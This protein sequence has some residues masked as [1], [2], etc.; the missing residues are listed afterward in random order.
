MPGM[1]VAVAMSGG[2][3]SAVAAYL[4]KREGHEVVGFFLHLNAPSEDAA[5]SERRCCSADDARDAQRCAE[6]LGIDFYALPYRDRFAAIVEDFVSEYRAGRTPYPCVHCNQDLKFGSLMTLAEGIGA[7]AVATGHYA[8]RQEASGRVRLLRGLDPDKDQSFVLFGLG[9]AQLARARFPV[10][11]F[12]KERVR[13][14]AREAGLPV[15]DKP[16]SQDLCFIPRGTA[17]EFLK[18]KAPELARPGQVVDAGGRVLGEHPGVAFFTVGQR[19]GLPAATEPRYVLSTDPATN[20]VV[21]GSREETLAGSLLAEKAGWII[22]A[23]DG[24]VR[25][26]VQIRYRHV[27]GAATVT[28]LE[29]GRVRVDFDQPQAAV[30]P[31]QPAVFYDEA[32]GQEVLGGGWIAAPSM[33]PRPATGTL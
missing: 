11:E 3:E 14:M 4:M 23:P 17:A 29:S 30:T 13:E 19:K 2:V 1:K 6:V 22:P 21:A 28:P 32:T 25:A 12:P 15:R 33:P 16:E 31:G 7:Q 18:K 9:Q 5:V 27:A 26:R 10:G 20:T 24:P 8:R